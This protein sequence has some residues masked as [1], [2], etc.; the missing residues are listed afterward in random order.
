VNLRRAIRS[1][2]WG[3]HRESHASRDSIYV[4]LC[5]QVRIIPLSKPFISTDIGGLFV[6]S[7]DVWCIGVCLPFTLT[8]DAAFF[9]H[10]TR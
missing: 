2:T 9:V 7:G 10:I 6:M 5:I 3:K 1:R 4:C 8:S